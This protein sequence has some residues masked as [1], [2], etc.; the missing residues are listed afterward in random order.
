MRAHKCCVFLFFFLAVRASRVYPFLLTLIF[1]RSQFLYLYLIYSCT[2]IF[3]I[4]FWCKRGSRVMTRN[5]MQLKMKTWVQAT[6][7]RSAE[8][9]K[10]PL[11]EGALDQ[12]T[13]TDKTFLADRI[14][15]GVKRQT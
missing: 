3:H 14:G 13:G 1:M 6:H 2:V 15:A 10:S 8:R 4:Y 9:L 11:G 7:A 12:C 5:Q